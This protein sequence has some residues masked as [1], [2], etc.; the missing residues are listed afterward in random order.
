MACRSGSNLSGID[1]IA[2]SGD[3]Q[4]TLS[5]TLSSARTDLA[6]AANSGAI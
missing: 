2:F 5:A 1:K 4:S 6:G 3:T